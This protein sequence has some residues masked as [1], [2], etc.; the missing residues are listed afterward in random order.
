MKNRA[1]LLLCAALAVVPVAA[2]QTD[3]AY[4]PDQTSAVTSPSPPP[5]CRAKQIFAHKNWEDKRPAKGKEHALAGCP[6][7]VRENKKKR[8]YR[9]R[10]LRKIAPYNCGGHWSWW[11][12]PCYVIACESH[13][14][15][16]AANPSGAVGPYQL[17]GWGAPFPVR[18]WKDKMAHHRIAASLSLSNWVCA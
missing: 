6:P 8:F 12:K 5:V 18:S 2:A 7:K 13:F 11:A 3:T 17:L 4:Q 14:S 1:L 16:S 10:S 15:W 9:Y